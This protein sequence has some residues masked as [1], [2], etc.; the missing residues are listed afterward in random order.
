[1]HT[2]EHINDSKG[3]SLVFVLMVP[4]VP[5]GTLLDGHTGSH[6]NIVGPT[7]ALD[8]HTVVTTTAGGPPEAMST[9]RHSRLIAPLPCPALHPMFILVNTPHS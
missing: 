1:M 6:L 7:L 8:L 4:V 3:A 9:T 2:M 5:T